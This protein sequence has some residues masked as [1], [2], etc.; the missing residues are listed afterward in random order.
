MHVSAAN[1][2]EKFQAK[3][4]TEYAVL[5]VIAR[6][7]KKSIDGGLKYVIKPHWPTGESWMMQVRM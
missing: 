6:H 2:S 4:W 7:E 3:F 5:S 1:F